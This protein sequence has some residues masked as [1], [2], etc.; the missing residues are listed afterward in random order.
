MHTSLKLEEQQS[1]L[2]D[3]LALKYASHYKGEFKNSLFLDTTDP[4]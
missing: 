4:K 1:A 3:S 2:K